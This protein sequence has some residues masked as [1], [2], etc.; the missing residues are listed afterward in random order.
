MISLVEETRG[1]VEPA[2][3]LRDIAVSSIEYDSRKVVPGSLFAAVKGFSSDGFDYIDAAVA[4]GA[5]A[6]MVSSE[7]VRELERIGGKGVALIA[8]ADDRKG[9][10]A[11]ADAFYGH[12]S[13]SM[14]V[15]GVTGT[16]GKTSITYMLESVFR[17]AGKNPGVIGTVNYRWSNVSLAAPNTTPESKDLQEILFR[18][19]ADGVD[20]VIM[21]VSSHAL[22]LNRVDHISFD[23]AVFTNLTRDHMD[24][25][26]DFEDY[27]SSK[28]RLFDILDAG[29]KEIRAGAVNGDD[30][31]GRRI[32]SLRGRYSYPLISFGSGDHE[33]RVVPGSVSNKITG[34]KYRI[35]IGGD[36]AADLGLR[37]AGKFQLYN[38][39]AAF[40]AAYSLGVPSET[41]R[42]GL[43][44]VVQVPGRFDVVHSEE[45][46]SVVVDYAH[47]GDAML[48]LLQS[49][50]EL[51]SHRVITVFG[52]GGDRDK[53]K[54][55]IMGG[56]AEENSDICIVTSDNPRTEEPGAI[57]RDI[58]AGMK[59]GNHRV[60]PD[61]ET[62]I[63]EAIM[64][65]ERNDII[66]IAGKGHEDYQIL[67][68]TKIHFD[69][70]E[71][72]AKYIKAR[73]AR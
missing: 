3:P 11:L 62:A 34:L 25:H 31:Y 1:A 16:N 38:S 2:G 53:T 51:D 6:V 21:E 46:F 33:I 7:R 44:A 50:R 61:R 48:K 20:V 35:T 17:H 72:A 47:T 49:V 30:E 27:F 26:P 63:R 73:E 22:K 39:L 68:R 28:L 42:L 37:L 29:E 43:E 19:K 56:V 5:A 32:L 15:V 4:K 71:M 14:T 57:I 41:I 60:V 36:A 8:A 54:R 45:G 9:L 24:F 69:D 65:A 10:S 13:R 23:A 64:A 40:A 70:R 18:M 59:R 52:C 58:L 66:V 67:G 12:P 55:P